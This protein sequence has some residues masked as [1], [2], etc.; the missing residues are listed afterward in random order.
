MF[1]APLTSGGAC[2]FIRM[3]AV[4]IESVGGDGEFESAWLEFVAVSWKPSGLKA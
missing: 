4:G 3:G 2:F 1:Q